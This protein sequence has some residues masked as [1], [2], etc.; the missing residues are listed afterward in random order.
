[1]RA[2]VV[3]SSSD[4]LRR[5]SLPA[6]V[7]AALAS[8]GRPVDPVYRAPLEQR[9]AYNFAD[10]RIHDGE[11]AGASARSVGA[12]AY[13]VGRHVVFGRGEYRPETAGGLSL[14]SHE[15]THVVQQGAPTDAALVGATMERAPACEAEATH[16]AA[17]PSATPRALTRGAAPMLMRW[18]SSEHIE[19]G[20]KAVGGPAQLIT[21]DCHDRDFRERSDPGLWPPSWRALIALGTPEQQR[22]VTAG[23][24]YGEIVALSGDFYEDFGK[25][26]R[27]P[28]KEIYRLIPLVH[29]R[30]TTAQL[31]SATGGRY[32]DLAARNV[33]HFSA[34]PKGKSNLDTWRA[35]HTQALALARRASTNP[36]LANQ[37]WGL[38]AAADHFL[39]DAFSGGHIRTPRADLKA[40]GKLGDLESIVEH[41][42][43]NEYGVMVKNA[44][45]DTPWPAYGD[46]QLTRAGNEINRAKVM[47]GVE[48]SKRDIAEA[49]SKGAS[50]TNP[51]PFAAERLVPEA[52]NPSHDRWT[53]RTPSWIFLPEG[54]VRVEDDYTRMKRHVIGSEAP[55]FLRGKFHS[56]DNDVRNWVN[57]IDM[58]ALGHVPVSEKI[59]MID[60]LLEGWISG[61]DV[62]AIERL[63]LSVDAPGDMKIIRDRF[64]NRLLL[65]HWG[66]EVIQVVEAH[67]PPL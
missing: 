38:N 2:Y 27:A 28:L 51:V 33:S 1:M 25:L 35:M 37:A 40:Q 63:C 46:L 31:Q 62:V 55:G 47:E 59:R 66:R 22:A 7:L 20:D 18:D 67:Q 29:S 36:T 58:V 21:L 30:A 26:S 49:I 5:P 8:R 39:T 14:L 64:Y 42:L 56:N 23:L 65:T 4:G 17:A 60:T 11:I 48:L 61:E 44:R 13:T 41:D 6:G 54:T 32:L 24:T 52:I 15:L 10:V 9:L 43:D 45:G 53:G 57:D 12:R 34:V 50:F 3:P 16:V 19:L